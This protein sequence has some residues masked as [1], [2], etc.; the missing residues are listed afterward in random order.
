MSHRRRHFSYFRACGLRGAGP[1]RYRRVELGAT[2]SRR[3]PRRTSAALN[4]F[5]LWFSSM[6]GL[7]I[8]NG[9]PIAHLATQAPKCR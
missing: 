6:I 4:G 2:A 3:R 5:G 9:F 1:R 7:T 8:V